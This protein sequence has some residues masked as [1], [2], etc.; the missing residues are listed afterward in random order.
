M[1]LHQEFITTAKRNGD[2]LAIIDRMTGSKVT[3]TRALIGSLILGKKFSRY[4]DKYIGIMIPTSAGAM[5]ATIGTLIA[6]KIPVMINYSTGAPENCLYAQNRCKFETIITSRA[7]LE[8]IN[9]PVIDG[10][11]CIED[12]MSAV[13]PM[14]KIKA[15][16]FAK[17]PTNLIIKKLPKVDINDTACILFT[18]GSEKDPKGVQLSH[19]N[20]GSNVTD[21]IEVLKLNQE[22][23]IFS[24]L[25]LFHVFGIQTNFW[26]PLTLGMT[27]V[28]YANPLDYKN[29]PKIIREEGCTMIAAT[30]I[31]LAGYVRSANPGDF[32]SLEL[33]VAGADKTPN[34]LRGEYREKHNIEIVEGYGAT[35]TSPV[36]SVNHRDNNKPGSIGLVVPHAEVKIT[37][38]DTGETLPPGLEGK[39]LVKGDLVMKGYL[40]DDKT[41]EAIVDG[42]YYTGDIGV[43]DEDGFLWHR[44]RLKRFVKI[45][46]E[47]VSLV[48]TESAISELIDNNIDCCVVDIPDSIKGAS[49]VAVLT[50]EVDKD[51][52]IKDLSEHLPQIAIPKKYVILPELPKMGSGKVDFRKVSDLIRSDVLV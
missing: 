22:D 24:V 1:I 40:D 30:P 51:R 49:L 23:I 52:L 16:L 42:W 35:E 31:F 50:A 4:T 28:T 10:M 12:I 44:G 5:L 17:L 43:L 27:A 38:V 11:I 45:G 14:D 6:G 7:L 20:L 19:K 29:I 47:M 3:Y 15:A 48:N 21:V 41:K 33:V 2:K 13:K 37:N 18:S 26:M 8:K 36:V 39:I 25:P 46:G 32:K 9:C 34:W